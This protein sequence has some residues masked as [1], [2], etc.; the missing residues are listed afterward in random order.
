MCSMAESLPNVVS[1]NLESSFWSA[2]K[3]LNFENNE[4]NQ[5]D[6]VKTKK[7]E[8]FSFTIISSQETSKAKGASDFPL[9]FESSEKKRVS[10]QYFVRQNDF[11]FKKK[12][13][14]D[15]AIGSFPKNCSCHANAKN[16]FS[17]LK[18]C[19]ID[20]TDSTVSPKRRNSEN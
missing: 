15:E 13:I 10:D 16:E 17:N 20:E 8:R 7:F 18:T 2:S 12:Q 11:L 3:N 9:T 6:S 1:K 14:D 4:E 5:S 19:N